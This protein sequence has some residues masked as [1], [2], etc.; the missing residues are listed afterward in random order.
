VPGVAETYAFESMRWPGSY[1][2]ATDMG[3][4]AFNKLREGTGKLLK[5][6]GG[7]RSPKH[8]DDG[9]GG[10]ASGGKASAASGGKA[11]AKTAAGRFGRLSAAASFSEGKGG[12]AAAAV[13]GA[14]PKFASQRGNLKLAKLERDPTAHARDADEA[15]TTTFEDRAC[16]FYL[17]AVPGADRAH[18]YTVQSSGYSTQGSVSGKGGSGSKGGSGNGGSGGSGAAWFLNAFERVRFNPDRGRVRFNSVQETPDTRTGGAG[19][20]AWTPEGRR[21]SEDI[22]RTAATAVGAAAVADLQGDPDFE[23]EVK[24]A[25]RRGV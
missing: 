8:N 5:A 25:S 21:A 1:L 23:K 4:G 22:L 24:R 9:G 2:Q 13:A 19:P 14:A 18:C 17:G 10:A 11:P 7:G 15:A 6:K 12:A 3:V 20:Q 16:W